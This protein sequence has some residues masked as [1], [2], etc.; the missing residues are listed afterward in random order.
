MLSTGIQGTA[1]LQHLCVGSV[2]A[3]GPLPITGCTT[4]WRTGRHW[5][6]A[7]SLSSNLSGW[8]QGLLI[9][10]RTMAQ[11]QMASKKASAREQSYTMTWHK[12][13]SQNMKLTLS[14]TW[15]RLPLNSWTI[16]SLITGNSV[17]GA[18]TYPYASALH[19][20]SFRD[21]PRA[22]LFDRKLSALP[23]G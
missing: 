20:E 1:P 12:I 4:V 7:V 16:Q 5:K 15:L 22:K 18:G 17:V 14:F 6:A 19:L 21:R 9:Y 10:T 11:P 23:P 8:E 2:V 13:W 3:P